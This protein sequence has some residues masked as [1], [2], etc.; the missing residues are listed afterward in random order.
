VELREVLTP[1]ER[2]VDQR[3]VVLVAEVAVLQKTLADGG[4]RPIEQAT[5]AAL[6]PRGVE[7]EH[8]CG[9]RVDRHAPAGVLAPPVCAGRDPR[10]VRAV[11]PLRIGIVLGAAG[12]L[13]RSALPGALKRPGPQ[14]APVVLGPVAV[15][16]RKVLLVRA[17]LALV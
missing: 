11:A 5:P 4:L 6:R 14:R 8:A 13:V 9:V 7:V 15:D 16:S 10:D 3:A 1:V 2:D 17:V 12:A